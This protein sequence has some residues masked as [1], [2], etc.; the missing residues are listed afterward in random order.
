MVTTLRLVLDEPCGPYAGGIQECR[1]E[2]V[3]GYEKGRARALSVE[4]R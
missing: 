4:Y 2:K 3:C 1:D